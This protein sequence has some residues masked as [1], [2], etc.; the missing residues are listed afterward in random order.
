MADITEATPD[1]IAKALAD[2]FVDI[3]KKQDG[4][5]L[6]KIVVPGSGVDT[7]LPGNE[8]KVHYVGT[9][10]S[11]GTKFDSSRDR[12]GTFNFDVGVGQVITGWDEGICSMT[13]GEKCILHCAPDYAYGEHGSPPKIPGGA[14]LNF[15]VELFSWKEKTRPASQM[16][17]EERLAHAVKMKEVGTA[18]FK[19]GDL[20]SAV[21][22][23]E[24]GAQYVTYTKGGQDHGHSHGG[25]PCSGHGDDSDDDIPANSP[26]ELGEEATK[27]AV[28]LYN[29]CAMARLKAG[30]AEFARF[31]C[32]RV[33]ELDSVN[34]KAFFRRAQAELALGNSARCLDDTAKILEID[35]QNKE[36]EQLRRKA[37]DAVKAAKRSEKAMCAKMF[38]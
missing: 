36:A 6:K 32:T 26:N 29:N 31:D 11:N 24:E 16:S 23:Y 30:D 21:T 8:V 13:K 14:V 35:A 22:H 12:P 37:L 5:L 1:H 33:L 28:A 15:E 2:G 17:A 10:D 25:E 20:E 19:A 4:G 34:L 3:S 27:L 38:G 18:A 9:L 7:P